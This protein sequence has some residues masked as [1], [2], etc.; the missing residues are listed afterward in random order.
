MEQKNEK[1][2]IITSCYYK[3]I[4][5]GE[6]MIIQHA[7]AFQ[8]SGSLVVSDGKETVV[9]NPGDFRLN[10]RN[11]LAKFAKQPEITEPFQSISI[12]FDEELLREFAK[13]HNYNSIKKVKTTPSIQLKKHKLYA[14]FIESLQPYLPFLNSKNDELVRHKIKE[15]LLIL[16]KVQPELRNIGSS[17]GFS[18]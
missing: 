7:F 6:N 3:K 8:I 4:V 13:E 1:S 2:Q 5:N 18:C 11:K 10:I 12:S 14:S 9:F 15:A 17:L 16:L